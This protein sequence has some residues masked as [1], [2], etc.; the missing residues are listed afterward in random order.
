MVYSRFNRPAA[1]RV[2]LGRESSLEQVEEDLVLEMC[3]YCSM[4]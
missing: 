4:S 2:K 3:S 1:R